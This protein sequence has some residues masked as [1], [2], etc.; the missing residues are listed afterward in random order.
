MDLDQKAPKITPPQTNRE[1]H[2]VD[3]NQNLSANANAGMM[4]FLRSSRAL[5]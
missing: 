3:L 2:K 4:L 1:R 5:L